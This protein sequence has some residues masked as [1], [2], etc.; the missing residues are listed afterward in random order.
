MRPPERT[1]DGIDSFVREASLEHS[2]TRKVNAFYEETPFPNY[3]EYDSLGSFYE[4]AGRGV[5]A[6]L[7]DEQIPMNAS[8]LEC[9]CGT[10]QLSAFLAKG[11]RQVIGQDLC[12]NS[13]RLAN[14]FK[15]ANGI[16]NLSLVH[17]DI[18]DLP[19]ADGAFDLVISKGVLHHTRNCRL[20]FQE[21]ARRVRPGGFIIVGLYNSY[22]RW[23]S[24]VRKWIYRG[25]PRLVETLDY[26]LCNVA[27]SA[28]KRRAWIL[29]QYQNPHES[30][31]SVDE[32][33]AWF[34]E[35][36]FTFINA[37]PKISFRQ[38]MTT[39][40]RLFMPRPAGSRLEHLL[41]QMLWLFSIAREGALFDLIGRRKES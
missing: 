7:L 20:A 8:I 19:F 16:D 5:Y 28:E 18:F 41:M 32:V 39:R 17:A 21:I 10:G 24:R 9:G 12:L 3:E 1:I 22:A 4:K 35:A 6:R 38:A 11:R 26:V 29:D 2:I 37:M 36:E 25:A 23:P 30:W 13:L 15:A 40:D 27:V 33:L 34:E 14:A 31:H